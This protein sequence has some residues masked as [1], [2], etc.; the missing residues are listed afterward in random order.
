MQLLVFVLVFMLV[1]DKVL[2]GDKELA[3]QAF[4]A[5]KRTRKICSDHIR[6]RVNVVIVKDLDVPLEIG[7]EHW[8]LVNWD[9]KYGGVLH[10]SVVFVAEFLTGHHHVIHSST[11]LSTYCVCG[12]LPFTTGF[13]HEKA[14]ASECL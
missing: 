6:C 7:I 8:Q 3:T 12:F 14:P 1:R 5:S 2:H 10:D 11:Q 9:I 13:G 4:Y